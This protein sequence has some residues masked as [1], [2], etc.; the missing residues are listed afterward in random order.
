MRVNLFI[1]VLVLSAAFSIQRNA[2]QVSTFDVVSIRPVN[3]YRRVTI[4]GTTAQLPA[5][6]KPCQYL[7]TRVKCR[8]PLWGLLREAFG[9]HEFQ[10]DAPS[11]SKD[12]LFDF[13]ATMPEG[14]SVDDAR[15]MLQEALKERFALQFHFE[16][17]PTP[18]YALVVGPHGTTLQHIDPEHIQS[19]KFETPTGAITTNQIVKA[20]QY[21]SSGV[22]LDIFAQVLQSVA[23]LDKPVG[24]ETGLEGRY[25][26]D[27]KWKTNADPD[28]V[29]HVLDKGILRA[30]EEQLGLVLTSKVEDLKYFH[31]DGLSKS[32]TPN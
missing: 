1:S 32:P 23:D 14:T 15:I 11:W 7:P 2:Q 3:P 29:I 20:G 28:E 27:M 30:T 31:V 9:I 17:R 19:R 24:N 6:R 13:E 5:G 10:L 25:V 16:S 26:V 18:V 4:Q 22:P 12:D 8:L 21:F